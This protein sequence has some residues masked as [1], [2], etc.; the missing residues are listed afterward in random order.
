MA[1]SGCMQ[2]LETAVDVTKALETDLTTLDSLITSFEQHVIS[3]LPDDAR[4]DMLVDDLCGMYNIQAWYFYNKQDL[5][6]DK[7]ISLDE[8]KSIH[9]TVDPK[10]R[11]VLERFQEAQQRVCKYQLNEMH[12]EMITVYIETHPILSKYLN[13][14][15]E[16]GT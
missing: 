7:L 11:K 4:Q 12:R 16:P 1:L 9:K 3:S 15:K 6:D 14:T 2:G 13:V 5:F 8:R 10:E